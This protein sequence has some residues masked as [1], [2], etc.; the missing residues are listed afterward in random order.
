MSDHEIIQL[1]L[2]ILIGLFQLLNL[3]IEMLDLLHQLSFLLDIPLFLLL[4]CQLII[5]LNILYLLQH[6]VVLIG[7]LIDLLF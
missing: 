4:I 3:L 1:G 5:S 6:R 2:L 7:A